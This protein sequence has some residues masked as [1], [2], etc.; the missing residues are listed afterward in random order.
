MEPPTA[1]VLELAKAVEAVDQTVAC[2]LCGVAWW[3]GEGWT[4]KVED[5]HAE[6]CPLKGRRDVHAAAGFDYAY[7]DALDDHRYPP[8]RPA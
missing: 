5:F 3:P 4:P 7:L 8:R 2:G 6:G 1:E